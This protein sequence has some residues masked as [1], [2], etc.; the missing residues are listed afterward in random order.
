MICFLFVSKTV[1]V[2]QGAVS[3]TK[4]LCRHR[5]EVKPVEHAAALSFLLARNCYLNVFFGFGGLSAFNK[6]CFA[7]SSFE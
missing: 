7:L 2:L 3:L 6:V 1:E 4:G 5:W